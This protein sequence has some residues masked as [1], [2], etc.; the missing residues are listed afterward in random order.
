[1][2]DMVHDALIE[3]AQ[4]VTEACIANSVEGVDLQPLDGRDISLAGVGGVGADASLQN[5][6]RISARVAI[7][8]VLM[9][10][11]LELA[12]GRP[13]THLFGL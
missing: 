9:T 8:G 1:M 3:P 11:L 10:I 5:T 7:A 13:V 6:E 4:T 12:S 2:A